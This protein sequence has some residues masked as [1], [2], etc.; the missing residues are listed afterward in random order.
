MM[1]PPGS[2]M[3]YV[4]HQHHHEPS[5]TADLPLH[6]LAAPVNIVLPPL[7]ASPIPQHD[8]RKRLHAS[9][10]MCLVEAAAR[11]PTERESDGNESPSSDSKRH[12]KV[13]RSDI[14]SFIHIYNPTEA[15]RR[16]RP[17]GRPFAKAAEHARKGKSLP[18][19]T[20]ST[21]RAPQLPAIGPRNDVN[22]GSQL[23]SESESAA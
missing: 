8:D 22:I 5:R 6:L 18:S 7:H 4:L 11:N 21:V 9:G 19:A 3:Q 2:L 10:L 16:G 1:P 14:G 13:E 12:K 23:R 15:T 20:G 17:R